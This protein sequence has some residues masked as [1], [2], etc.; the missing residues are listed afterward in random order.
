MDEIDEIEVSHVR[1]LDEMAE[2][3]SIRTRVFV[4]EQ[5]VPLDLEVDEYDGDPATHERVGVVHVLARRG[6]VAVG[7]ARLLFDAP[8]EDGHGLPHIGR[9][10]VLLEHRRG[11][12]GAALMA[13]LHEE[14]RG[15]GATGIAISAQLHALP[16]YEGLGYVAAGPVYLEAGIDHRAMTLRLRA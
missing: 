6:G 8:E 5:G 9:V 14:A 3:L 10:A 2:A 4:E 12:V 15:R 13:A 11:G 16:F 7:T 1:T